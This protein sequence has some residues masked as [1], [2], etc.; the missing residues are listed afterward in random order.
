MRCVK[1][2]EYF[3]ESIFVT[4][5]LSPICSVSQIDKKDGHF[6]KL[7]NGGT[8][9]AVASQQEDITVDERNPAQ[10]R[11]KERRKDRHISANKLS[12][13]FAFTLL[14]QF[15][16]V[17]E[18]ESKKVFQIPFENF[19]Y[20]TFLKPRQLYQLYRRHSAI[21]ALHFTILIYQSAKLFSSYWS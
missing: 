7:Q 9:L 18:I 14:A 8:V 16:N 19:H 13:S 10:E 1:G 21:I 4:F 11:K 2:F 12:L 5:S 15:L 3:G 17:M 20:L 6:L